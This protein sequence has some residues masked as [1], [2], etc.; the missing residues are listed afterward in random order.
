M[1]ILLIFPRISFENPPSYTNPKLGL[2]YLSSFL[3][4]NGYKDIKIID[5]DLITW[6]FNTF[7]KKVYEYAPDLVGI[8]CMSTNLESAYRICRFVRNTLKNTKIVLGGP[9]FN[10]N[11]EDIF[12]YFDIDFVVQREG[13]KTLLELVQSLDE[14]SHYK[15]IRGLIFRDMDGSIVKNGFR[16]LNQELDSLPFPDY[17]DLYEGH[18]FYGPPYS[19]T[20]NMVS[21]MTSRG[22]PFHCS[23]CDVSNIH[24]IKV[25]TRSVEN[26]IEEIKFLQKKYYVNEF[27]FKDSNFHMDKKWVDEFSDKV[28]SNNMKISFFANYRVE[29]VSD[30]YAEP[31]KRAGCSLIFCGIESINP[32]VQEILG[33]RTSINQIIKA[34]DTIKKHRIKRLYSFMFGSPMDTVETL[35]SYIDFAIKT[36]PFLISI[37][38]TTAFP[39]T[40]LYNYAL[41]HKLLRDPKWFYA[42][43]SP[44]IDDPYPGRMMME[45]LSPAK[46]NEYIRLAYVKF[47]LR[48]NKIAEFL[49]YFGLRRFI[50]SAAMKFFSVMK[51]TTSFTPVYRDRFHFG[52]NKRK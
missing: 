9:H 38:P 20:G 35:K 15:N 50:S 16:E 14:P 32:K 25:R 4:K 6:N 34:N 3:K 10:S 8:Q 37:G 19:R 11:P 31:L 33:K 22:C 1:K 45:H 24:G 26:V 27:L 29:V 42:F 12:N 13:E 44:K 49:K 43:L 40:A 28:I 51:R 17:D 36:D 47:Y 39:G 41:E 21:L 30:D 52:S 48:P 46:V 7:C 18:P 5:L 23:F 2:M